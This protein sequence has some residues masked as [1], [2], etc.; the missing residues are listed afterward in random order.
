MSALTDGLRYYWDGASPTAPTGPDAVTA[1][2]IGSPTT[3][4]S[5][6]FGT[7]VTLNGSSQ[8]VDTEKKFTHANGTMFLVVGSAASFATST[9]M[10][11]QSSDDAGNNMGLGIQAGNFIV[12]GTG[13][14]L[15]SLTGDLWLAMTW[16]SAGVRTFVNGA[17][18]NT[19]AFTGPPVAPA[20]AFDFH[21]GCYHYS[22]GRIFFHAAT[23]V[24]FA[25]FDAALSDAAIGA[26]YNSD[27]STL[28][29]YLSGGGGASIQPSSGGLAL[30]GLA[31]TVGNSVTRV[32]VVGSVALAGQT[33]T[34]TN[35]GIVTRVPVAGAAA[36]AGLAP[37]VLQITLRQPVAGAL[38][39]AG[40][41]PSV[42]TAGIRQPSVG[43]LA[44]AGQAPTVWRA[45]TIRPTQGALALAGNAPTVGT[46]TNVTRQPSAGALALAGQAPSNT[47]TLDSP[48][49][50]AL[51]LAGLAPTVRR[52]DTIRPTQ[53]AL[54]LAGNAPTVNANGSISKQPSTGAAV[55]AGNAPTVN[56]S[57]HATRQP[58][59]AAA[60]LATSAPIVVRA[61]NRVPTAGA[62]ALQGNAP[63][64]GVTSSVVINPTTG[65]LVVNGS[66]PTVVWAGSAVVT[67]AAGAL[68]I[69][70][71]AP[72]VAGVTVHGARRKHR[73]QQSS[74]SRNNIQG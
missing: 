31:A 40:L 56:A 60:V 57:G 24:M 18:D 64:V 36:L 65:A 15:G 32:P 45:D 53:G 37:T 2:L 71:T 7:G 19:N 9:T 5:T 70:S 26:L 54:A 44:L 1:T 41:A 39:I 43:A 46:N 29:T 73:R 63:T 50:A 27:G 8:A 4:V 28:R 25:I 13:V 62:M 69:A 67:P 6:A 35:S 55:L 33:A 12:N 14:S 3:G 51:V 66:V 61:D 47:L 59:T 52:A 34:V 23:H 10:A 72:G 16:G 74:T 38:S 49:P 58:N 17:L 48:P 42:L 20:G 21:L 11:G 22:G 30:A 68:S